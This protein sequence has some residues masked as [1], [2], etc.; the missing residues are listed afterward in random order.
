MKE[1]CVH[2]IR[3]RI[4]SYAPDLLAEC[5]SYEATIKEAGGIELFF[6]GV[7]P[8]GHIAFNEPGSSLSS[9]ICAKTLIDDTV[10]VDARFFDNDTTQVPKASIDCRS[11]NYR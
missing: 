9:R 3:Q 7:G 8:D 10:I 1:W 11:W 4:L 5:A 6:G 2:Y